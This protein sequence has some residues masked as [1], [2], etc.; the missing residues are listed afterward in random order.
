MEGTF[1]VPAARLSSVQI[2]LGWNHVWGELSHAGVNCSGAELSQGRTVQ[3]PFLMLAMWN[4][5][6]CKTKTVF[7]W[8][9]LSKRR[10]SACTD[11]WQ[12]TDHCWQCCQR[13]LSASKDTCPD[14][15]PDQTY[16]QITAGHICN[17]TMFFKIEIKIIH[18]QDKQ[19]LPWWGI[20]FYFQF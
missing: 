5:S 7:L 15:I 1:S 18:E 17:R 20:P 12:F 3:A 10:L 14:L 19:V 2:P 11:H 9:K 6:I 13:R 8:A 16:Y 4:V